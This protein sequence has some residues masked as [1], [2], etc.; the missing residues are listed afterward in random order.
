MGFCGH[1]SIITSKGLQKKIPFYISSLLKLAQISFPG[2]M[3]TTPAEDAW[4]KYTD[5]FQTHPTTWLSAVVSMLLISPPGSNRRQT[6]SIMTQIHRSKEFVKPKLKSRVVKLHLPFYSP[7]NLFVSNSLT[8]KSFQNIFLGNAWIFPA[9]GHYLFVRIKGGTKFPNSLANKQAS[10]R[11]V[12][13]LRPQR[14][15]RKKL[16]KSV[17]F[18]N[19]QDSPPG[20]LSSSLEAQNSG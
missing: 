3:A 12:L 20:L 1:L 5:A 9:E 11:H 19:L 14:K 17:F 15:A 8:L 13:S 2:K 7:G 6:A 4:T 18:P 10:V 16:L